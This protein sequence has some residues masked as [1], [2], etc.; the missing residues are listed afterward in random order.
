MAKAIILVLDSL[1]IGATPDAEKF[2]DQ[3]A[4]TLGH[5]AHW[6]AQ[7]NQCEE[8]ATGPLKIPNL[9]KLGLA[10]ANQLGSG[11]LPITAVENHHPIFESNNAHAGKQDD[12]VALY[13]ACEE[14]ST[15]KDTPSGHWEMAGVAVEFD[16]GFFPKQENCFPLGLV[17]EIKKQTGVKDIL[18][19]CHASGTEILNRLGQAH[20]DSGAP[21]C[22]TSADSVFQVAA[23]EDYFGLDNLYA[24]CESVRKILNE[25]NI[26][27]VIARPFIGEA[28]AFTR[29]GNRKDYTTPPHKNTLLDLLVKNGREVHSVGKIADIFAHRG[30]THKTKATGHDALFNAT[31]EAI[32]IAEPGSLIFTNFVEFDQSFG[33]RRNIGGYAAALEHFD[34]RL[35]EVVS[36]M[37]QDD[38][39]VLT[40]DHGCDPTWPG[41]DHT[42]EHVPF[43][44]YRPNNALE[45]NKGIRSSFCDIG[46]SIADFLE[47][48]P[49][50][51]GTSVFK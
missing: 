39:L 7:G 9:V 48:E 46:Q 50:A 23:H 24:F 36:A 45:I 5:I 19:N 4:N 27:R 20:I 38:L 40:A 3:G 44:A 17:E 28:G 6:C 47:I 12:I 30:I 26:G 42:R 11:K 34:Q 21:I 29:T 41:S 1:G 32:N 37:Q 2:G 14:L 43:I 51:Q 25:Y 31:I 16:W 49:L 22:Y 18:G 8:R 13:S 15:G 35:P 10:K 33:H